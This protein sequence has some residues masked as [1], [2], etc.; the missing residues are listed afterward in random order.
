[1]ASPNNPSKA[2]VFFALFLLATIPNA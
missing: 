1:M 2:L